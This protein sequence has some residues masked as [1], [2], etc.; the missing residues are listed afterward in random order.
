M[1]HTNML[2][3]PP[4]DPYPFSALA[5]DLDADL[6]GP[7]L[8]ESTGPAFPD[9]GAAS[10]AV[11]ASSEAH[12]DKLDSQ[13]LEGILGGLESAPRMED[14]GVYAGAS[15]SASAPTASRAASAAPAATSRDSRTYAWSGLDRSRPARREAAR[16]AAAS[17]AITPPPFGSAHASAAPAHRGSRRDTLTPTDHGEESCSGASLAGLSSGV[18][19]QVSRR[20]RSG[21][22]AR[23]NHHPSSDSVCSSSVGPPRHA[24]RHAADGALKTPLDMGASRTSSS[25]ASSGRATAEGGDA[26]SRPR[27]KPAEDDETRKAKNRAAATRS[28]EK[29][30]AEMGE[31]REENG[32]LRRQLEAKEAETARIRDEASGLRAQVALLT[33]L[34]EAQLCTAAQNGPA[35][36]M[37]AAAS[38][39]SARVPSSFPAAPRL[40]SE[41]MKRPRD[42]DASTVSRGNSASDVSPR[43]SGA[44]SVLSAA[45]RQALPPRAGTSAAPSSSS[46]SSS[47][48][49]SAASATSPTSLAAEKQLPSS[50]SA[51]AAAAAAGRAAGDATAGT[52]CC[53][54]R[55]SAGAGSPCDSRASP[56]EEAAQPAVLRPL[57]QQSGGFVAVAD[58]GAAGAAF[59]DAPPLPSARD[60]DTDGDVS[61]T[62]LES[63]CDCDD[64]DDCDCDSSGPAAKRPRRVRGVKRILA[65]GLALVSVIAASL[66]G[67]SPD[68]DAALGSSDAATTR[69]ASGRALLAVEDVVDVASAAPQP[70]A[71]G[72]GAAWAGNVLYAWGALDAVLTVLAVL[73][74]VLAFWSMAWPEVRRSLPRV[75]RPQSSSSG[76]EG[77]G[78]A[79][80][81]RT[82]RPR[83]RTRSRAAPC[84]TLRAVVVE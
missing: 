12:D 35:A 67:P 81:G 80:L 84:E 15:P 34:L 83:R 43:L 61:G 57:Q 5:D 50:M 73:L 14:S 47:S 52:D 3:P 22:A 76:H 62:E 23:H 79:A 58:A 24:R 44:A 8:P 1:S 55:A 19:P 63:A 40:H 45:T 17:A 69:S 26:P 28:R 70:A 9:A 27:S 51:V 42:D 6:W 4:L 77:R 49:G 29:R 68:A 13:M 2:G 25:S 32:Q 54:D 10:A 39:A 71:A 33:R 20:H 38:A 78:R 82:G 37:A 59:E 30:R 16:R 31:L 75:G 66:T 46:S 18:V 41:S 72:R 7:P 65:T 74:C 21:S 11:L 53:S 64:D 48:S 56:Y 36:A 60:R